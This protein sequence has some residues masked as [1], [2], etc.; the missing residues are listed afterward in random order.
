MRGR[1]GA[2][3]TIAIVSI[4]MWFVVL[5][6]ASSIDV[7]DYKIPDQDGVD[8]WYPEKQVGFGS[9]VNWL[10]STVAMPTSLILLILL[11]P[12]SFDAMREM[13]ES[14]MIVDRK[15]CRI[16]EDS[17][18]K[19]CRRIKF[20][21]AILMIVIV[22]L[23]AVWTHRDYYQ[24]VGQHYRCGSFVYECVRDDSGE[25]G[26]KPVEAEKHDGA[27]Y[28]MTTDVIEY[29]WSVAA[30]MD[31]RAM[32][33]ENGVDRERRLARNH[34][35]AKFVYVFYGFGH[36]VVF[37]AAFLWIVTLAIM[38]AETLWKESPI[39][40]IPSDDSSWCGGFEKLEKPIRLVLIIL[41]A[42]V[43]N[44]YLIVVQNL[45]LRTEDLSLAQFFVSPLRRTPQLSWNS[46]ADI[47]PLLLWVLGGPAQPSDDTRQ[48][49]S[50][51]MTT[52]LVSATGPAAVV[53]GGALIRNIVRR[54]Y[55]RVANC[56]SEAVCKGDWPLT[57]PSFR[58]LLIYAVCSLIAVI[59]FR[60]GVLLFGLGLVSCVVHILRGSKIEAKRDGGGEGSVE[61]VA[62]GE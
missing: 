28:Y 60:F 19:L 44:G 10:A 25:Y 27:E 37:S 12:L 2:I 6:W 51:T 39:L 29:D 40:V 45:Y 5:I 16:S 13:Y 52:V 18:R 38:G 31:H 42:G 8:F 22:I 14:G 32:G 1:T 58:T 54:A 49:L 26:G 24:S 20:W 48:V 55:E 61:G 50:N 23:L 33:T 57:W 56:G 59:F 3:I 47:F 34:G 62:E 21:F 46:P 17:F 53:V 7:H 36:F 35:F 30:L 11:I 9:A 4:A 15:L 43:I 41:G